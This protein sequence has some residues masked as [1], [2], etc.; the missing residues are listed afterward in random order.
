MATQLTAEERLTEA[1]AAHAVI[2]SAETKEEIRQVFQGFYLK[3]GH[4]ALA[5]MLLG[6]TP[7]KALRISA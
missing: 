7:E 5:R 1:K 3:L 2:A 6:Q 4:K